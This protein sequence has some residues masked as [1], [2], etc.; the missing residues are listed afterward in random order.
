MDAMAR[1]I[2]LEEVLASDPRFEVRGQINYEDSREPL[3]TE[4]ATGLF[5]TIAGEIVQARGE[6]LVVTINGSVAA[7]AGGG[8]SPV[9]LLAIAALILMGVK[10]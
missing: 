2:F 4:K 10:V 3:L 9:I 8:L 1:G 5:V 7:V 6:P